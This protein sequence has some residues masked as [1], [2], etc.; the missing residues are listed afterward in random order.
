MAPTRSS[1]RTSRAKASSETQYPPAIPSTK[2]PHGSAPKRS[3]ILASTSDKERFTSFEDASRAFAVFKQQLQKLEHLPCETLQFKAHT[4]I[5]TRIADA[6]KHRGVD[7]TLMFPETYVTNQGEKLV[8]CY[9]CNEDFSITNR[10]KAKTRH[11]S[12]EEHLAGVA[13]FLRIEISCLRNP[14]RCYLSSCDYTVR[15]EREDALLKHYKTVHLGLNADERVPWSVRKAL[16]EFRRARNSSSQ[17]LD[18][19]FSDIDI[20]SR[21]PTPAPTPAP[22]L[23]P[24]PV[25]SPAFSE[26]SSSSSSY[27]S[28]SSPLTPAEEAFD[29]WGP[30]SEVPSSMDSNLSP[31]NSMFSDFEIGPYLSQQ[32]RS[33]P[34]QSD[35]F[36]VFNPAQRSAAQNYNFSTIPV[37]NEFELAELFDNTSFEQSASWG[38]P[39]LDTTQADSNSFDLTGFNLDFQQGLGYEGELD[40]SWAI[41]FS[42][43]PH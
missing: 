6:C 33:S 30:P 34:L 15:G 17:S 32:G 9:V 23:P 12:S 18:P 43:Y 20:P 14:Y 28:Y 35:V 3:G 25:P 41:D 10:N 8:H 13:S 26:S 40:L 1:T 29:T 16:E 39:Q 31:Q 7:H 37:P 19:D 42:S 11:A 2:R 21:L 22:V 24:T 36:P 38:L 4:T 27:S 5:A